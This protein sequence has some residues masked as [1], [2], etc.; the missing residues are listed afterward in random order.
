MLNLIKNFPFSKVVRNFRFE[1]IN[2]LAREK[3]IKKTVLVDTVMILYFA[4]FISH[5]DFLE[6]YP[7]KF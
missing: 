5:L 4:F 7:A 6:L 3:F 1:F 2:F